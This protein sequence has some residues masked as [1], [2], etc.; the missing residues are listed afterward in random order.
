MVAGDRLAGGLRLV[1]RS[2]ALRRTLGGTDRFLRGVHLV[3]PAAGVALVVG[4]TAA[5]VPVAP[6]PALVSLLG[7]LLVVHRTATRPPLDYA[8][9]AHDIGLLGP[10]PLGLVLQLLRGPAL[11]AVLVAV[12]V[13]ITAG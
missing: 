7:A 4:L 2:S 10:L 6:L 13:A 3:R 12:Q 1:A 5:T 11:L 9:S 8:S